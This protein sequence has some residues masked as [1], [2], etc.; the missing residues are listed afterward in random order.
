MTVPRR[1]RR[2]RTR[3]EWVAVNGSEA[4]LSAGRGAALRLTE[5]AGCRE[6]QLGT[7]SGNEFVPAEVG[8]GRGEDLER[9]PQTLR[10]EYYGAGVIL[11]VVAVVMDVFVRLRRS[12]EHRQKQDQRR[13]SRRSDAVEISSGVECDRHDGARVRADYVKRVKWPE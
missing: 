4:N 2:E 6:A 10:K 11:V 1:F 5:V 9:S 7:E 8:R 3:D 12:G 13:R